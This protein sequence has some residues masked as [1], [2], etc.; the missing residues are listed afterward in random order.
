[1]ITAA[2]LAQIKF[3]TSGNLATDE[4]P[5]QEYYWPQLEYKLTQ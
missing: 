2:N 5:R 3:K 1:M 4:V